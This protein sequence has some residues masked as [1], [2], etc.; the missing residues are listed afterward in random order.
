MNDILHALRHLT[1]DQI[2]DIVYYYAQVIYTQ[3]LEGS[4]ALHSVPHVLW[5][6]LNNIAVWVNY[7]VNGV[8]MA[9]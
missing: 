3:Q 1:P 5:A 4:N 7:I 8:W 2:L 6:S 9:G